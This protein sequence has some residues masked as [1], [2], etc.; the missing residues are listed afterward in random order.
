[1]IKVVIAEDHE[2]VREGLKS[3]IE[4][5]NEIKVIGCASDGKEAFTL[6]KKLL[7][8]IVLMDL[9]MPGC[10]GVEGTKLIKSE[11]PFIKILVLSSFSDGD[12]VY[13]ALKNGAEGYVHKDIKPTE[14]IQLI[15]GVKGGMKIVH[16]NVFFNTM[17]QLNKN[18]EVSDPK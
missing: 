8:D 11:F 12:N 6:C 18:E 5:D 15:K 16:P 7:P 3:L 2:I 17:K 1:M 14:L 13:A 4:Q 9:D 10:G